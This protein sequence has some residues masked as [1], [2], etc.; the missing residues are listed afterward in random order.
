M[1]RWFFAIPVF[2]LVLLT[3]VHSQQNNSPNTHDQSLEQPMS[4]ERM[5][6]ILLALSPDME[7]D[8]TRFLLIVEDVRVFVITLSLIH[9]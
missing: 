9:I 1:I 6:E 7:S 2:L 4:L 5:E 8:G 3:P